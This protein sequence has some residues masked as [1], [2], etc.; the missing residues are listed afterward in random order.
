MT[1]TLTRISQ[2]EDGTFGTLSDE[3]GVQLCV[4]CEPSPDEAHP[5][6]PAI[7]Y[8]CIPHNGEHWKNVWEVANVPG[9]SAILIHAGNSEKDTLGCIVVGTGFGFIGTHR[10]VTESLRALNKLRAMLP[11]EFDFEIKEEFGE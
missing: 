5:C 8:R 1:Y 9:R 6:I 3:S 11:E 7:K 2:S 4:T 10:G